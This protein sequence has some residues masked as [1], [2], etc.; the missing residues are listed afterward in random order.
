[1]VR[2]SGYHYFD[3]SLSSNMTSS[4]TWKS[5]EQIEDAIYNSYICVGILFDTGMS[6]IGY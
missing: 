3:P 4:W 6:C 2:G 1:M 5:L